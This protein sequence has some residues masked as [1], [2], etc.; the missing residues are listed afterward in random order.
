MEKNVI[1][2]INELRTFVEEVRSWLLTYQEIIGSELPEYLELND[3]TVANKVIE[4]KYGV[5]DR[6]TGRSTYR[7]LYFS[8][9]EL[10]MSP[11]DCAK[12]YFERQECNSKTD[13]LR[14]QKQ[15]KADEAEYE[16]LKKKLGKD[17]PKSKKNF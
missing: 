6:A 11:E 17:K 12:A 2:K 7:S 16:R 1:E 14:Q 10:S 13:S 5:Y 9:K 4:I 8:E 3:I 15:L